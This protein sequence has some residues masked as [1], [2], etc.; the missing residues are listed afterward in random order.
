MEFTVRVEVPEGLEKAVAEVL[1]DYF[2]REDIAEEIQTW[3]WLE[4]SHVAEEVQHP[5]DI[6][7]T[8]E[9]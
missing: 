8:I 4:L 6:K 5:N 1:D 3:L 7:V 9:A 2:I